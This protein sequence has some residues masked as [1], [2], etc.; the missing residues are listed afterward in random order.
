M[1]NYCI[2]ISMP[3]TKQNKTKHL[4]ISDAGEG[5]EQLEF[6]YFA[7][8]CA[9]LCNLFGKQFA[10]SYKVKGT[11]IIMIWHPTVWYLPE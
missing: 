3:K 10:Y 6:L 9:K 1:R 4:K 8:W 7:V 11:L 5:A 2:S